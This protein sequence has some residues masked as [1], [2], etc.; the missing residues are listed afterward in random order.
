MLERVQSH[1][2]RIMYQLGK[3]LRIG[4]TDFKFHGYHASRLDN[5]E[6]RHEA[7]LIE[8]LRRQLE[9][10][11]G[12]FIDVGVNVGQTLLKILSIDRERAYIGF[13]PQI[14]CCHDVGKFLQLNHLSNAVVLPLALSDSNG[15]STFYMHGQYDE[16]ASLIVQPE[17]AGDAWM[18]SHIQTRIGDEVL[19][20]LEVSDVCAIKIDVE[21]AELSVLRGLEKTLQ[22]KHPSIIFEVLPNFYG[23]KERTRHPPEICARNQ[24]SAE[25]L[26][27]LLSELAYDIFQINEE[28]GAEIRVNRFELD[29]QSAFLGNNFIAHART[30]SQS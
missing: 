4:N 30:F 18:T 12:V 15:I 26:F 29:D 1:A 11:P 8:V 25:A 3:K 6:K 19:Q 23:V 10:R 17:S 5:S 24:A 7:Y 9:S 27:G 28:D 14:P 16:M 13:E 20:E 21:G 22:M 2:R